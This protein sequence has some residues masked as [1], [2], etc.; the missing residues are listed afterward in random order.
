MNFSVHL[1]D[2]LIDQLNQSAREIGK[3]RN[4]LIREAVAQWL[5]R[6][7]PLKWPAEV[8]NFRGFAGIKRFEAERKKL[9][10][11]RDPF[12]ALSA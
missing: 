8:A 1:N 3:T 2:E 11:P 5:S 6:R 9:K 12:D 4:A 7:R 10:P